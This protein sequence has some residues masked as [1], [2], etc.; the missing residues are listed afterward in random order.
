MP[1]DYSFVLKTPLCLIVT[2]L[3]L[4]YGYLFLLWF[5]CIYPAWGVIEYLESVD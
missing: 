5:H 1:S 3:K 4:L 2:P